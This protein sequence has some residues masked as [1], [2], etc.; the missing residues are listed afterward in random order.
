LFRSRFIF[1]EKN[2]TNYYLNINF[3]WYNHLN[4]NVKKSSWCREEE[5]ILWLLHRRLGNKWSIISKELEG[6]TDNTIKNHWNSTMRKRSKEISKE[7]EK[8]I[9]DKSPLMIKN[10][11]SE[12]LEESKKSLEETNKNFFEEKLK[13]YNLFKSSNATYKNKVSKS[14]MNLRTHS[15]KIK[16]RGRKPKNRKIDNSGNVHNKESLKSLDESN[17]RISFIDHSSK[18]IVY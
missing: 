14:H 11:E 13:Q 16:K 5:W 6:R 3:R 8:L 4:P 7:F 9:Q 1:I 18:D 12:I 17:S 10:I 15:K 2:L